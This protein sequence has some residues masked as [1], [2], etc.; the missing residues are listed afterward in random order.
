MLMLSQVKRP[1]L[2]KCCLIASILCLSNANAANILDAYR[3]AAA[4]DPLLRQAAA[5]TQAD[6]ELKPQARA[7]L[8]PDLR[9]GATYDRTYNFDRDA[10]SGS[11][12]VDSDNKTSFDSRR[13]D[14]TLTQPVYDREALYRIREANAFINQSEADFIAAQQDLVLRV[15]ERYFEVLEALDTLTFA[16]ADKE[17]IARQLEQA[18]R[19]YEVGL[20]TITDV[21][22]AQARFDLADADEISARR[23]LS[24]ARE[25]LREVTGQYYEQINVLDPEAPLDP[26]D[27]D[28][29]E[30]WV[31]I[32]LENNPQVL[33]AAFGVERAQE[34]IQVQKSGHYPT[35]NFRAQAAKSNEANIDTRSNNVGLELTIPLYQGGAVNSRTREA[36]YQHEAAKEILERAQRDVVRRTR[37]AYIGLETARRRVKALAQAV[38]SNRSGLEATQAGFDVGTRTIVD[39]LDAERDL[40]LAIRDLAVSRYDYI[41]NRLRLLQAAG[42]VSEKQMEAISFW[43]RPPEKTQP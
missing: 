7:L 21:L 35:L 31:S 20:I 11:F 41:I 10:P 8:L 1:Q 38:K 17:A 32:A 13:Y 27:P 23:L 9:A 34:N 4:S 43:L 29:P 22:E 28:D 25:A 26:V 30:A 15:A 24:D 36:A 39:V 18:K 5:E 42:R 6:Q 19:R 33:S 40:L 16:I 37:D 2:F 12:V 14:L 3:D